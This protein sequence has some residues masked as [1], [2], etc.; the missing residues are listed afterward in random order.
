MEQG[1]LVLPWQPECYPPFPIVPNSS[2][3]R[4]DK[5]SVNP[6]SHITRLSQPTTA[7]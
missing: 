4:W 7:P 1:K 6:T 5:W 2:K 3:E